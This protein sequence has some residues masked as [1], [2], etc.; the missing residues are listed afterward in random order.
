MIT[1]CFEDDYILAVN[2]PNNV[3][4]HHSSMSRN[5][6]E[7]LSL[8]KLLFNQFRVKY[9]PLHRLDRKTSGVILFVKNKAHVA[10]CQDLFINHKIQKT[11]LGIVRGFIPENGLIDTPV[12]GRDA[13]IHKEA[14]TYF[15]R[16]KIAE[17]DIPVHP[18][19]Q[20]RYSLIE[21]KPQTGRLHQLR[22]H[23]NKIS[24][25]L[26]GDPKYGDRYHN[27]M[28]ESK[29]NCTNMF[30]HAHQLDFIHPF[31]SKKLQI[32]A[33]LPKDWGFINK[34]MKW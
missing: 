26:I 25:P 7:E 17:I 15:K 3:L 19:E 12:K 4:V 24:H 23:L 33:E 1:V 20:S 8:V 13:N 30:L 11:Y 22:I 32:N 5:K 27:R 16:L 21:L 14:L 28:F 29:F 31:T 18:Y 10:V 6:S 9:Y 34:K 2:K